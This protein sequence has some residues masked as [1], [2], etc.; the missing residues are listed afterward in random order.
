MPCSEKR[1]QANRRN[2]QNSTGPRTPAGKAKVARNAT[3]HG[4]CSAEIVL[5]T[6]DASEYES[7]KQAWLDD[8]QP[9]TEARRVLVELAAAHAWRLR[10]CL[11]AEQAHFL[12]AA[13]EARSE[14]NDRGRRWADRCAQRLGKRPGE[15]VAELLG[16]S[17]GV[18]WLRDAWRD[19]LPDATPEGWFDHEDHHGRL[20]NLMGHPCDADADPIGGA[21]LISW[22]LFEHN[23][24]EDNY[25]K[26][27]NDDD[28]DDEEEKKVALSDDEVRALADELRAAIAAK[29]AELEALVAS[30]PPDDGPIALREIGLAPFADTPRGR[31]LMRYEALHAREFRATLNQLVKLSET[32][33]DLIDDA[34]PPP[35]PRPEPRPEPAPARPEAVA[36]P[37]GPSPVSDSDVCICKSIPTD[38]APAPNKPTEP[39]DPGASRPSRGAPGAPPEG[40]GRR[41]DR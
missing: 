13:D 20:L 11:K 18:A 34:A 38:L 22:R 35:A 24:D 33:A 1:L 23:D 32:G 4:L 5:P 36:E 27:N 21:A 17:D 16:D 15:V 19:L 28:D 25:Y 41:S 3:K 8:W 7:M 40:R 39:V 37:A 29:V 9:P 30:A 31:A 6:E 12:E 14:R 10:R 26:N 2:A